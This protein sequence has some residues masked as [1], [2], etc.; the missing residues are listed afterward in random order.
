MIRIG[1]TGVP[2]A[3]KTSLARGL[4]ASLRRIEGLK[5]VEL[6]SEYARRY[7]SKHGDIQDMWEQYRILAK[8]REWEDSVDNGK[9]DMMISD[10]PIF[11]G[12]IYCLELPKK[13][14]KDVMCFN[15]VFKGM[16]KL[17]APRSRYDIIF[18]L[19]PL[20][21]PVDDG[22]RKQ[23]YFDQDLREIMNQRIKVT[24]RDLFPPILYKEITEVDLKKRIDICVETIKG[25]KNGRV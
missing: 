4:C 10:S 9:I 17:N 8:Q 7:I 23:E 11:L 2:G 14:S 15:D 19:P 21:A 5:N 24:I 20:V 25:V 18:H 12:F 13:T 16:L 22:V 1:I 3:G 6:V